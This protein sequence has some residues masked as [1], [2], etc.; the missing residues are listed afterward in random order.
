MTASG[1]RTGNSPSHPVQTD[2]SVGERSSLSFAKL[3]NFTDKATP[4]LTPSL[5]KVATHLASRGLS[6]E[7]AVVLA[8]KEPALVLMN[9]SQGSVHET[10]MSRRTLKK[11]PEFVVYVKKDML[12]DIL[13]GEL[14]P[15]E[16][17]LN[18]RLRYAGDEQ[19]GVRIMHELA[20]SEDAIFEPRRE[21]D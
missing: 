20:I 19:I 21:R 11:A 10:A 2:E 9:L 3:R 13:R 5:E 17:F 6:G 7:I 12:W 4:D 18:G 16:A 8:E 1:R 15:G 14:S